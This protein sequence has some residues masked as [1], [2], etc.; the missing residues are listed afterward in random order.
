MGSALQHVR[1]RVNWGSRMLGRF[2]RRPHRDCP[3][4]ALV[5]GG[6]GSLLCLVC[7]EVFVAVGGEIISLDESFC[8]TFRPN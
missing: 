6:P 2:R 7:A 5:T 4:T 3:H 1:R 8:R